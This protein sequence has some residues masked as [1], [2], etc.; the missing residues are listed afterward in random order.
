MRAHAHHDSRDVSMGHARSTGLRTSERAVGR[1]SSA[2]GEDRG[3]WVVSL[4]VEAVSNARIA[5]CH[6]NIN[7]GMRAQSTAGS[8]WEVANRIERS[9]VT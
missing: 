8:E 7:I 6:S 2:S 3:W 1:V 4:C 9:D 5:I